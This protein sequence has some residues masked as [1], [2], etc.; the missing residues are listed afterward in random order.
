MARFYMETTSDTGPSVT[1]RCGDGRMVVRIGIETPAG[2]SSIEIRCGSGGWDG[3]A[4][5]EIVKRLLPGV[6]VKG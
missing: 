6:R 2:R 4:N 1:T 3:S 5:V